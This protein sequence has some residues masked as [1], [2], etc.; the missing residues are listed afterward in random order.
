MG[1][2][3]VLQEA[4]EKQRHERERVPDNF[5]EPK[6]S[7]PMPKN[8]IPC[9]TKTCKHYSTKYVKHCSIFGSA[10]LGFC[11]HY[12]QDRYEKMIEIQENGGNGATKNG[13]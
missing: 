7:D 11:K 3:G 4:L 9:G 13:R 10:D 8:Q 6:R 5:F 2:A 1:K 12:T